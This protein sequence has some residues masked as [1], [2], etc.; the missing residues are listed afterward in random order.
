MGTGPMFLNITNLEVYYGG[1]HALH[2]MNL[3]IEKGEI[4]SVIGANGAGKSTLLKTIAGVKDYRSGSITFDGVALPRQPH[5]VVRTGVMLVPEGRRIFAPL[6]VYENLM[7]GSYSVSDRSVIGDRLDEVY[8]L[9][10]VLKARL[11]QPGGTLSGGEQQMLAVARALMA[12][13]RLLLLDEPSLGLAPKVV[14]VLFDTF[15][16]LNKERGITILL[17]EQNASMALDISQHSFVL[18]TGEIKL[19]GRGSELL[20]DPRVRA[21][22]LGVRQT[23][24]D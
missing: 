10:P 6:S 1:I 5:Q 18:E 20:D 7:L 17:V 3:H 16:R 15:I 13:P 12:S 14:D 19:E 22:Y 11:Q 4:A 8:E 21:S 2:N 9:F 23:A 24:I